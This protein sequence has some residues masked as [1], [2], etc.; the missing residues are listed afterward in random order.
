[1]ATEFDTRTDST[2]Q[3]EA[4]IVESVIAHG[5]SSEEF[6]ANCGSVEAAVAEIGRYYREDAPEA[7]PTNYDGESLDVED[8]ARRYFTRLSEPDEDA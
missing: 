1:M 4:E 8:Y 5:I 2:Y 7:I 3:I 6:L